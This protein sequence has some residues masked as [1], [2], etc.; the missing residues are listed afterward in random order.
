VGLGPVREQPVL[1]TSRGSHG[2]DPVVR[3]SA[4]KFRNFMDDA[5]NCSRSSALWRRGSIPRSPGTRQA[6]GQTQAEVVDLK[7]RRTT[8]RMLERLLHR[9]ARA[10]LEIRIPDLRITGRKRE[11]HSAVAA[12]RYLSG[13]FPSRMNPSRGPSSASAA[14]HTTPA[15]LCATGRA[16]MAAAPG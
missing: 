15:A 14:A 3:H 10:A 7:K 5:R 4:N 6:S 11:V 12:G 8:M 9:N 16:P 1:R 13:G 2:I